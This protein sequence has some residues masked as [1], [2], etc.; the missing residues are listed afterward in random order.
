MALSPTLADDVLVALLLVAV[1]A[2]LFVSR[3]LQRVANAI[4][5]LREYSLA[6]DAHRLLSV[7]LRLG[8]ATAV[9]NS[10]VAIVGLG[11]VKAD[12]SD[13]VM[14]RGQELLRWNSKPRF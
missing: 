5:A 3:R 8:I 9:V 13:R 14:L 10:Q 7:V 2:I 11:L 6:S 4:A 1:L 12:R